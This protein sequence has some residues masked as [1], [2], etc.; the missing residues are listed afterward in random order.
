MGRNPGGALTQRG[1]V[2]ALL[3]SPALGR[4]DKMERYQGGGEGATFGAVCAQPNV[5]R[6]VALRSPPRPNQGIHDMNLERSWHHLASPSPDLTLF[7]TLLDI[8]TKRNSRILLQ[9]PQP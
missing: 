2:G 4:L 9:S 7:Q 3:H 8:K 5:T 1:S 6:S